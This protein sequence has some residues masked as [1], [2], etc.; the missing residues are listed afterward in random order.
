MIHA[1]GDIQNDIMHMSKL[2][3]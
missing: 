2:A 3:R 1:F